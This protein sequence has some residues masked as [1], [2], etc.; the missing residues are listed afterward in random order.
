MKNFRFYISVCLDVLFPSVFYKMRYFSSKMRENAS[1]M[2]SKS[3]SNPASK[4]I[5]FYNVSFRH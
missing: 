2:H 4:V 3:D 5:I 1:K